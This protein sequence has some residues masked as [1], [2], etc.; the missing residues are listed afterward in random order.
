MIV[1]ANILDWA[2]AYDG[3]LFHAALMDAPY[4][5]EFMGK[6][7]DGSGVSFDPETWRLI[8]RCLHP[9]AYLFVMA[10]TLNDDLISVAMRQAGLRKFHKAMAWGYSQ[11]FPKAT[12]ID[13]AISNRWARE[14]YGGWCECEDC[15][16]S[17]P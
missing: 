11:G 15:D 14:N 1:H 8:A 2:R 7:W 12:R 10:G 5:M 4:E 16:D 6:G 13:A 17:T 3:S 9:G